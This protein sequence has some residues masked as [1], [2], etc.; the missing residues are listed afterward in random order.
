MKKS[1][2]TSMAIAAS[3]LLEPSSALAAE[4]EHH[5]G[6]LPQFN[7]D[8]WPSQIF[9]LTIFFTVLYIAFS[10][11]IL[12]SMGAT[13]GSRENYINETLLAA[14]KFSA[15]ASTL[16]EQVEA[17][18]KSAGQKAAQHIQQ[19]ESETATRLSDAL[20]KFRARYESDIETAETKIGKA[21]ALAMADMQTIATD[22][23]A[24]AA[25]KVSGL[26]ADRTQVESLIRSL[27]EKSR[28]A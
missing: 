17:N 21:T 1:F 12:P 18:L 22:L 23:A 13:I 14:E 5:G 20:S 28:A 25:E 19:A 9:W 10:R 7:T 3:L 27:S 11:F 16:K 4:A 15:E 6:G 26:S 8:S 2:L 24:Q